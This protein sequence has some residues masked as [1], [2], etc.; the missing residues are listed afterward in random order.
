MTKDLFLFEKSNNSFGYPA[1]HMMP[2]S[3]ETEICRWDEVLVIANF[4]LQNLPPE[5]PEYN[6]LSICMR[7]YDYVTL[8][9]FAKY[10]HRMINQMDIANEA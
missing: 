9:T 7:G 3:Y 1:V 6:S 5:I 8:E 10:V 4:F 2:V